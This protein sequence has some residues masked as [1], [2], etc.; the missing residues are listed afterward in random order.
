MAITNTAFQF[1]GFADSLNRIGRPV[2]SNAVFVPNQIQA[3]GDR[4]TWVYPI[5]TSKANWAT[6]GKHIISS[7][8]RL[9]TEKA[10][11]PFV[12]F[13]KRYGVFGAFQLP[14]S[15]PEKENDI[16][17]NSERWRVSNEYYARSSPHWE[18]LELWRTISAEATWML[19]MAAALS[20]NPRRRNDD[21]EI[22]RELAP[23]FTRDQI[24]DAQFDLWRAVNV[25]LKIGRVQLRMA[26]PHS[27]DNPDWQTEIHYGGQFNLFGALATQ[28]MLV[29]AGAEKLY[30]CSGCRIPYVRKKKL[31]KSGQS[32]YCSDPSCGRKRARYDAD[33]R[34]KDK[35]IEARKLASSGVRVR[36]IARRLNLTTDTAKRWVRSA[37]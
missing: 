20:Q 7:F 19:R 10:T 15:A 11:E 16:L 35:M 4:L 33:R 31:P 27:W 34:R 9:A 30:T 1:A 22:W 25:W 12:K 6:P 28:L 29:I 21:P 24:E 26:R 13:A 18:P 23:D 2:R 14:V 37:G 36:E 3:E 17:F 5:K 8:L 32:N